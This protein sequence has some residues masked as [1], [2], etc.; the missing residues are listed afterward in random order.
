MSRRAIAR[1]VLV[2]G[3]LGAVGC[4]AGWAAGEGLWHLPL[5]KAETATMG[6]IAESVKDPPKL[7][8]P[9]KL[10]DP[11][12]PL[13]LDP[14][15]AVPPA[16]M[17]PEI[18]KRVKD[19]GGQSGPVEISLHWYNFNDLDLH[20]IDP[21]N[22]EI[23]FR[24]YCKHGDNQI[25]PSGGQL[26]VD[27]NCG[28]KS[29]GHSSED[30]IENIV[31]RTTPPPGHYRVDVYHFA[32]WQGT[33]P[34]EYE[35]YVLANGRNLGNTTDGKGNTCFRGSISAGERPRSVCE[36]DVAPPIPLRMSLPPE[37]VVNQGGANEMK[38]RIARDNYKG[39]VVV[40]FSGDLDGLTFRDS[41]KTDRK[42]VI[43]EDKDEVTLA[44]IAKD[45]ALGGTHE[46][47]VTASN[48]AGTACTKGHIPV[49]V[50]A[51]PPS[52]Q[53][54]AP[55]EVH[56]NQ[57]ADIPMKVLVGRNH[58]T[59][60]VTVRFSGGSEGITL[61]EVTIPAERTEQEVK[62]AAR[63]D[64]PEGQQ[65]VQIIA[66]SGGTPPVKA[67]PVDLKVIVDKG[68]VVAKMQWSWPIVL[69]TGL[70]TGL[71]AAGLALALVMGQ[72]RYLGRPLL[73]RRPEVWRRGLWPAA[74]ARSCPGC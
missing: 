8:L 6:S 36:F 66:G 38:L 14:P 64:A 55:A 59:G 25:A 34:T 63:S 2:F 51:I 4:L 13:T 31:W 12:R 45:D 41:L 70:W 30:P 40:E 19:E 16:E 61:P 50:N 56:V 18:K 35:L 11:P 3:V 71:L 29:G 53:L 17:P 52:L 21:Q 57:G 69:A 15:P 74:S 67:T 47:G 60:P 44:V 22:A 42:V 33:D 5:T 9:P 7:P 73:S 23:C 37:L 10:P 62:V 46:I 26:D 49:R 58:F 39:N 72:N 48:E 1:K 20:C 24:H 68:F 43:P 27:M 28:G 54:S 32:K 65:T